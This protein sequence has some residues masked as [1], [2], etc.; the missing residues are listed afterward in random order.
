M[1]W[2][3]LTVL[4]RYEKR[5]VG[6]N[7]LVANEGSFLSGLALKQGWGYAR[8]ISPVF[9]VIHAGVG[10]PFGLVRSVRGKLAA[11]LSLRLIH[12]PV[13]QTPVPISPGRS[14]LKPG[15]SLRSFRVCHGVARLRGVAG[16]LGTQHSLKAD[17][18]SLRR[19]SE[20]RPNF[21]FG[22]RAAPPSVPPRPRRGETWQL[23][24]GS[25][26]KFQSLKVIF[27]RIGHTSWRQVR[28]RAGGGTEKM[29]SGDAHDN[30]R[31]RRH[32]RERDGQMR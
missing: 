16:P 26:R 22:I 7:W 28:A 12:G 19:S 2:V 8:L 17:S 13:R 23:S 29:S 20:A 11:V 32:G 6:C 1:G 30:E 14:R 5:W 3:L 21:E 18:E 10:G 4:K 27:V 9:P 15:L 31:N 25:K 24:K